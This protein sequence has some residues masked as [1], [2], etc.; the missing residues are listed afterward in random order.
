VRFLDPPLREIPGV[1][2]ILVARGTGSA[3]R[4]RTWAA[5]SGDD[6]VTLFQVVYC[7]AYVHHLCQGFVPD[8]EVVFPRRRSAVLGRADL[9]V[10]PANADVQHP[11]QYVVRLSQ[12]GR[13]DLDDLDLSEP[14]ENCE[15]FHFKPDLP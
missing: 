15:S 9:L 14:W 10:R 1:T 13:L 7:R 3:V 11:E 12:P 6:N 5:H 4:A 8:D 2:V